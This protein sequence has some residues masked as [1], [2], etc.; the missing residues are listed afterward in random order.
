MSDKTSL[1]RGP[2][3]L[4]AKTRSVTRA[5][6]T[7]TALCSVPKGSRLIG[8][9]IQGTASDAGT[10]A[11]VSFG[12]SSNANEYGAANVLAAGVGGGGFFAFDPTA[13][14]VVTADTKIY[15]IY[16]ESGTASNAG[17]WTVTIIYTDG[18]KI[19]S[20]TV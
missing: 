19:N 2:K 20:D 8:A 18:N 13:E 12:S 15:A 10:S 5:M 11:T 6:T 17:A 1:L 9:F 14:T 16:A 3:A 7:G 4:R